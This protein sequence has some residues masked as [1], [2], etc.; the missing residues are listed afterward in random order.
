[1]ARAVED[2]AGLAAFTRGAGSNGC[3]AGRTAR[4]ETVYGAGLRGARADRGVARGRGEQ[5]CVVR[6]SSQR[7]GCAQWLGRARCAAE[8]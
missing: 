6:G 3:V 2:L 1:M 4:R 8:S 7:G 5:V